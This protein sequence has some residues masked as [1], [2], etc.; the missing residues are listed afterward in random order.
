MASGRGYDTIVVGLGAM[1]SATLYH[2]AKKGQKVLG[3]EQFTPGHTNGSSHGDSRIIRE[4]YFE[5]PLYV[6]LAQ[7]ADRMW[8]ELEGLTYRT[9]MKTTGGL[10][11]GP[12][13]GEVVEGTLRSARE[14]DLPYEVLDAKQIHERFPAFTVDDDLVG[15]YDPRAGMLDA[16]ACNAAH[17]DLARA[18]GAEAKFEEPVLGVSADSNGVSIRTARGSYLADK[19]VVTAGSWTRSLL[20]E[21]DLPL[22]IERETLF[23]FEPEPRALY[24]PDRFPIF[25]YEFT[26]GQINFGLARTSRGVKAGIHHSG[27]FVDHPDQVKRSVDA[28]E[29]ELLRET[30]G[31][32][33]P[34]LASA[35]LRESG[36]CLYTNTPDQHFI[37]D[38]HPKNPRV[39][40]SSPCS[41][42]GFKFATVLGEAQADLVTT[43]RSAFDLEPFRISRFEASGRTA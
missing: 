41:G 39:L 33:L 5:H 25:C 27:E 17:L 30:L 21:L 4:Q 22:T 18:K 9:L 2:L 35:P 20:R 23:W 43:G 12:A 32:V 38:W 19:L 3:I 40:V 28:S 37:V 29:I 42:H 26:P 11:I 34:G 15:A 13:D 36:V 6:P 14:H 1:G 7:R 24:E 31:D 10:M 8:R 16:D